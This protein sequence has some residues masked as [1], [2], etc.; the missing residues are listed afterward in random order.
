MEIGFELCKRC[1]EKDA[2]LNAIRAHHGEEPAR[3]PETFL[4][5]AAD[6]ISGARPGARRASFEQYVQ[7]LEKLE[8]MAQFTQQFRLEDQ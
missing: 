2:V 5:T 3:Y 6:A 4:V 7:R 8:E 1:G